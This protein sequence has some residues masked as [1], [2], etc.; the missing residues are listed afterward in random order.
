MKASWQQASKP[1]GQQ[2]RRPFWAAGQMKTSEQ[3]ASRQ[4]DL[5][6]QQAR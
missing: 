5:Y 6:G 1:A 3:Q 2:A 4:G